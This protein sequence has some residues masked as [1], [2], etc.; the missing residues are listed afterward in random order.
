MGVDLV[1]VELLQCAGPLVLPSGDP[2]VSPLQIQASE[3]VL[4]FP[5]VIQL[6]CLK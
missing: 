4:K 6:L 2:Q 3:Q 1:L 5:G